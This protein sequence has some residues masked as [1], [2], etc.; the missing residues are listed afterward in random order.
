[1]IPL[2]HKS[3]SNEHLG[4]VEYT[5]ENVVS[6]SSAPLHRCTA[7][8]IVPVDN[9]ILIRLPLSL[10]FSIRRL[11]A[12]SI[13][14]AN[15]ISTMSAYF[16]AIFILPN[17]SDILRGAQRPYVE[18]HPFPHSHIPKFPTSS[19]LTSSIPAPSIS[20]SS[21]HTLNFSRIF[22]RSIIFPTTSNVASDRHCEG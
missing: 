18:C 2:K 15:V 13:T 4:D 14:L 7:V 16:Q 3:D 10:S 8:P 1:M 19:I 11:D 17:V 12:T 5:I 21:V 9:R 22:F 6:M 20:P